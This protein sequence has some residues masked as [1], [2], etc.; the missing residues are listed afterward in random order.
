LDL[1]ARAQR[2]ALIP[3]QVVDPKEMAEARK[4]VTEAE[5]QLAQF[6]ADQRLAEREV[7]L[8]SSFSVSEAATIKAQP[9]LAT[10]A[11]DHEAIAKSADAASAPLDRTPKSTEQATNQT[12]SRKSPEEAVPGSHVPRSRPDQSVVVHG[13]S[14]F[15]SSTPGSTGQSLDIVVGSPS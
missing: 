10:E 1:S 14:P 6:R 4:K 12:A 7:E 3:A 2:L 9:S 5:Q 13:R 8:N 11:T 15:E